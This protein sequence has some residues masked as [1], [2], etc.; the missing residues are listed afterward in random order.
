MY[1][2]TVVTCL[3]RIGLNLYQPDVYLYA[4]KPV[5]L[6]RARAFVKYRYFVSSPKSSTANAILIR[7]RVSPLSCD[8]LSPPPTRARTYERA[9]RV[10]EC[11]EP[12]VISRSVVPTF[13]KILWISRF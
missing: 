6:A 13:C 12:Y 5:S 2:R 1:R 11:A 4:Y 7:D 10:T 3:R 8:S 9:S